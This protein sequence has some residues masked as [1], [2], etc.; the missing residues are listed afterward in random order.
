MRRW[1]IANTLNASFVLCPVSHAVSCSTPRCYDVKQLLSHPPDVEIV[2]NLDMPYEIASSAFFQILKKRQNP[3]IK[4]A[5]KSPVHDANKSKASL[6][7]GE[8]LAGGLTSSA[9]EAHGAALRPPVE[10]TQNSSHRDMREPRT[11][12]AERLV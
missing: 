2:S 1:L 11:R 8:R 6:L 3:F 12:K 9:T 10:P 5:C 7:E 4:K